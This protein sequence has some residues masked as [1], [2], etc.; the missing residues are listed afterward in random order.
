ML[1]W[2]I[3][4]L[5]PFKSNCP[6]TRN[7]RRHGKCQ[8]VRCRFGRSVWAIPTATPGSATSKCSVESIVL[9]EFNCASPHFNML[10]SRDI[11][12]RGIFSLGLQL[13]RILALRPASYSS[14]RPPRAPPATGT[15][16]TSRARRRRRCRPHLQGQCGARRL[17]VEWTLAFGHH[18]DRTPTQGYE[19]TRRAAMAAFVKSWRYESHLRRVNHAETITMAPSGTSYG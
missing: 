19:A 11:I 5:R 16:T 8:H 6:P 13:I 4:I 18:E 1:N 3:E 10:L 2:T 7:G 9:L 15:M 17:A 14:A 12:C